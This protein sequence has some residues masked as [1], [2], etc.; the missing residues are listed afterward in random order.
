MRL[1]QLKFIPTEKPRYKTLAETH[2]S[3]GIPTKHP[4]TSH[5]AVMKAKQVQFAHHGHSHLYSTPE[6]AI[7][8]YKNNINPFKK[9]NP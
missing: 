6:Q 1:V 9:D 5:W 3:A 7:L 2:V 4:Q 8:E